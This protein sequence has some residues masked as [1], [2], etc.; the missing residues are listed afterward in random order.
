[1]PATSVISASR[2]AASSSEE[3]STE[4]RAIIRCILL[5]L[6]VIATGT[7][8]FDLIEPGWDLWDC[9]YFTI[10]TITTVGYGDYGLS[11][12]GQMFAA[13][14][15]VCGLGV[16][17]YGLTTLVRYASDTD[18]AGRRKMKRD[19]ANCHDHIV[20]CGYVRMGRTIC[21]QVIRG[22]LDCVII[23]SR[24][25][26]VERA[27]RDGRLV[28][29]GSA[30]DDEVL[31]RAGLERARGVVCAVDSD[32]EN[33][34]I[35][36]T[37]RDLNPDIQ[38]ISRAEG[39]TAGRK[40][41]MAGATLVVSPHQMAGATAAT[42]LLHPRLTKFMGAACDDKHNFEL[43]ECLIGEGAQLIGQTIQ[44]F[45]SK[46]EALVFVAIERADGEMLIRPRGYDKFEEGDVVIF[47]GSDEDADFIRQAAAKCELQVG[48]G[49][50][51][52]G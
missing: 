10:V 6:G 51:V 49:V 47:A 42:A 15:M 12:D 26:C 36:V 29:S 18:A 22:G 13:G 33:M 50:G 45:G 2:I 35:T 8:G 11:R 30:S 41:E 38:I 52:G 7:L 14:L 25:D 39:D 3:G 31:L 4:F 46:A 9:F 28:I 23:E 32:A 44:Q 21:Q 27:K 37:A 17:T 1:M 20:I 43:G 16:F 19:I 40:L 24:E 48:Y 5:M 34:F